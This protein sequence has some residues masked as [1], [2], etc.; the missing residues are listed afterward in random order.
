MP[1]CYEGFDPMLGEIRDRANPVIP[2]GTTEGP[3]A[4]DLNNMVVVNEESRWRG[5][6]FILPSRDNLPVVHH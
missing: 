2:E 4:M 6:W 3:E 1:M 5:I